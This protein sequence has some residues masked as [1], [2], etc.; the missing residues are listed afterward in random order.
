MH[1]PYHWIL[2]ETLDDTYSYSIEASFEIDGDIC[3]VYHAVRGEHTVSV[4]NTIYHP[5]YGWYEFSYFTIDGANPDYDNPMD[6]T[7]IKDTTITAHYIWYD[8]P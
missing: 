8:Y 2:T 6:V 1:L 3:S 5:Y 7:I 4:D